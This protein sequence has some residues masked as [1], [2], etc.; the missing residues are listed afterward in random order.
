MKVD[1]VDVNE[2]Y[3]NYFAA[4]FF[5]AVFESFKDFWRTNVAK[6]LE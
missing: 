3:F 1:R 6:W 5:L 2:Y 4:A